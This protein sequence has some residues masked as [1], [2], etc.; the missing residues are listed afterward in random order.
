M[1]NASNNLYVKTHV[2][3]DLLHSGA[4]F[5]YERL[6]VWEYVSNGLQYIDTGTKPIV[7]VALN[8]K[9]KKLSIE[10]NGR[11]MDWEALQNYFVMHGENI[12]RKQGR[13]G[14]GLFGTGK[15]AAFGIAETLRIT[16]VQNNKRSKVELSKSDIKRIK[17]GEPVPIKQ[18]EKEVTID[19][20]NG[21][22]IEVEGIHLRTL[23][24]ADIIRY[25]QRHLA[26]WP[27]GATVLV[28]NH[29][30]EYS[31]PPI[32]REERFAPNEKQKE[33]LG[34]IELI[35]K[36]SKSPLDDD[37]QGITIF[38]NGVWYETTLAGNERRDMAQFI[39]GEVD[40]PALDENES[41]IP[42][43]DQSRSMQLNTNNELVQVLHA[44]I[45][46]SVDKV[47]RQLAKEAKERRKS[48]D[49][50]KLAQEANEISKVIN[51]DFEE[52]RARIA[53]AQ[54][55]AGRGLD[56]KARE[57]PD[58]GDPEN[59]SFGG[60]LPADIAAEEGG[61]GR[62]GET[63]HDP[64][65]PTSEPPDLGPELKPNEDSSQDIG[66]K[67]KTSNKPQ[68][69]GGFN[70]DFKSLGVDEHRAIYDSTNRTIFVNLDHPQLIAA[71]GEASI[72]EPLF[73]KLSYEI[74]FSEYAFALAYLMNE[75]G[76]Y[77]EV[78]DA[79]VE[80]RDT[81][82]RLAKRAASLYTV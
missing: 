4:Q 18:I 77:I 81:V 53:K 42:V 36:V 15:S 58:G 73:K 13:P 16:T 11:G 50:K 26:R 60:D 75:N 34:D 43:I 63:P 54:A 78:S 74:A 67:S 30:C 55:I 69:K 1:P 37:M 38:S 23:N 7:R 33:I 52:F 66:Q 39:L 41:P 25:I 40:V 35:I 31:E 76:N 51:A 47:R 5:K 12:D 6:V 28:N 46:G 71:K 21:T 8:S 32:E 49:A 10:D 57:I 48:E 24:Q 27:R 22:L 3:R 20:P 56:P 17:S 68:R 29:E 2:A 61:I 9:Q 62:R 14:R 70:V 79:I 45:G 19:H 65:P 72:E 44:F 59:L 64:T 82:N 80:I